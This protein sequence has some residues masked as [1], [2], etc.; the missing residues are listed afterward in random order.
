MHPFLGR[1]LKKNNWY[2]KMDLTRIVVKLHIENH[3]WTDA[4]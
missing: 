1:H 3:V 2:G 4:L